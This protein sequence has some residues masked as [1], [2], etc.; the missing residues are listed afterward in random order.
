MT[1]SSA[2]QRG[3][4]FYQAHLATNLRKIGAD[5]ILDPDT[6]AARLTAIPEA[7]R[8][9]FSKKTVNVEEAAREYAKAQGLD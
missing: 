1:V 6:G 2:R 9:H 3:L 5:A 8:S 7:V 4:S